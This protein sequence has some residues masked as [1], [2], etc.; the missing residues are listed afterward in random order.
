MVLL[1]LILKNTLRH[2]LRTALTV[3]GLFVAVLAFGLLQTVVGAWYAGAENASS[4]RL[5]TRNAI[6]LVFPLPLTYRPKLAAI[7][8]VRATTHANWFGGIYKEAK[9]FFPQFAVDTETYFKLYPEYLLSE[10][11]LRSFQ[12]DRRG[13]VVGRKLAERYGFKVGDTVTLKGTIFPGNWEFIVRGIYDG[14]DAK[15]DT[16]QFFLHWNYVNEVMKKTIPRRA[17]SVGVYV[18]E[19]DD[20]SRAAQISLEADRLFKNSQ[21]ETL[22]ETEQAFQLGFV[23]MT[24]AI[25]MAIRAVSY[26]VILIILAVMAN[27]LSMTA[28]E[29]TR[30]YATLKALGFAPGFIVALIMGESLTLA[31]IGGGLGM[32]ALL[33][34]AQAFGTAMGSLFPVFYVSSSTLF[35]QLVCALA[36]GVIAAI[37]PAVSAA[38]VNIVNGL[39][40]VA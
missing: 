18:L 32:A 33:P 27:T 40:H 7:D 11:A 16:N 21:A 10:D 24:E 26:L 29:R 30:E 35:A 6:S 13:A 19:I 1:R 9:N 20:P 15:T 34:I 8:G 17:N 5:V 12:R 37:A 14:R 22:T 25:V 23:S 2:R 3:A 36:V 38:R 28:R 31:L 4:A 39:R